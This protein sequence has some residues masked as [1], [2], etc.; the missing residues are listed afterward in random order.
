[1]NKTTKRVDESLKTSF[2]YLCLLEKCDDI[3]IIVA[4]SLF[5]ITNTILRW[6]YNFGLSKFNQN[7]EQKIAVAAKL[8]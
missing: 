1:M 8:E 4:V 3:T 7:A 5:N 2:L 6:S